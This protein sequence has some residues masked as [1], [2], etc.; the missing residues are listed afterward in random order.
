MIR[1]TWLPLTDCRLH[2]REGHQLH[3]A[4]DHTSSPSSSSSSFSTEASPG[5]EPVPLPRGNSHDGHSKRLFR[6]EVYPGEAIQLLST[7]PH[8]VFIAP[9]LSTDFTAAIQFNARIPSPKTDLG[10]KALSVGGFS[11]LRISA[12]TE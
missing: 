1:L 8:H 7:L 6:T 5:R 3:R 10:G 11:G 12:K 4:S 9:L 2:G